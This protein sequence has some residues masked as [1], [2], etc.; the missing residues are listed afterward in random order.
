MGV[1]PPRPFS[2]SNSPGHFLY[3]T[4]KSLFFSRCVGVFSF[5]FSLNLFFFSFLK[6]H[7]N[8]SIWKVMLYMW[9]G[10][11]FLSSQHFILFRDGQDGMVF[12]RLLHNLHYYCWSFLLFALLGFGEQNRHLGVEKHR[13]YS[14]IEANFLIEGYMYF[15]LLYVAFC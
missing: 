2:R 4:R 3:R 9:V 10:L 11:F 13:K 6:E 8:H 12:M 14:Y 7:S 15:C 5:Y 1:L